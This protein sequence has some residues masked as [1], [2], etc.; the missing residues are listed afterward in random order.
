MSYQIFII[1][2]N[3]TLVINCNIYDNIDHI[4][5]KIRKKIN[6]SYG[7]PYLNYNSKALSSAKT[8]NYYNIGSNSTLFLHFR[9]N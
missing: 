7:Y 8:L 1:H 6:I 2:N 4:I 9:M 5:M 3:K